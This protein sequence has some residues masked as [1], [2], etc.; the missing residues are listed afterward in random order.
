MHPQRV[1]GWCGFW[2]GGVIWPYFFEDEAE[3]A[4][5]LNGI[6]YRDMITEFLS[7]H[8]MDLDDMWFQQD[9]AQ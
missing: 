7:S 8:L 4:V 2:S 3:I 1:T 9:G 6:R 5:T